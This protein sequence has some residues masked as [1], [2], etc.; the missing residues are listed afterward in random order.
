M[1]GGCSLELVQS[2]IESIAAVRDRAS[3]AKEP[4]GAGKASMHWEAVSDD[5]KSMSVLCR[6]GWTPL[7]CALGSGHLCS[8]G[9][10][11]GETGVLRLT[12]EWRV[13]SGEVRGI[14]PGK[15]EGWQRGYLLSTTHHVVGQPGREK[16]CFSWRTHLARSPH[17]NWY[18]P[19]VN[20]FWKWGPRSRKRV[21]LLNK[22]VMLCACLQF[23]VPESRM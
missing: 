21:Y 10:V 12:R 22:R 14:Q 20:H 23:H 8:G 11:S 9:L 15:V 4:H 17:T 2:L 5:T 7:G 6:D 3:S 16:S 13:V 1:E 19:C 18:L